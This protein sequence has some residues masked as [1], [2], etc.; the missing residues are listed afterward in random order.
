ML[1]II[2]R[3]VLFLIATI[4]IYSFINY[5]GFNWWCNESVGV[6]RE[7]HGEET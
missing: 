3:F 7:I 2:S 5:P 6:S 4:I 1:P